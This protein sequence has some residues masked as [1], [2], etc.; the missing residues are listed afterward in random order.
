[1]PS[2]TTNKPPHSS[3]ANEINSSA[4][5]HRWYFKSECGGKY[6]FLDRDG[7]IV[8]DKEGYLH[9]IKDL[10]FIPGA[11]SGLLKLQKLGYGFV[12]I[13]NQ[14]GIARDLYSLKDAQK[15]NRALAVRLASRGIKIKKIYICP[16]HPEFTGQCVC[17]K[18]EPGLAKLAAK[19]FGVNLAD[20]FFIGDKDCDIQ[21]GK[22]CGGRT[23]LI[24]NE[25]YKTT[26][27]PD[28]RI[29]NILEAAEIIK[30]L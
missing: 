29:R 11:V 10:K 9:R 19:E 4:N 28:H 22:N 20:S 16:H 14:A 6:I 18:P 2:K 27:E 17:R 15:F 26:I 1:M 8:E 5:S 7:T 12:I 25:Q 24:E 3:R 23:F 30:N 13:S 21:L